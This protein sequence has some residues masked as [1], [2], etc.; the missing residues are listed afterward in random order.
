MLV[1]SSS[2]QQADSAPRKRGLFYSKV[3]SMPAGQLTP[4]QRARQKAALAKHHQEGREGKA[5]TSAGTIRTPK[6]QGKVGQQIKEMTEPATQIIRK[7]VEGGLVKRVEPWLDSEQQQTIL[8]TDPSASKEKLVLDNGKE[9]D[10]LATY[11]PVSK[12]KV[13][14]A[15]WVVT[16]D[17]NI[18]KANQESLL[19]KLE[20]AVKE[21]K[22][23]DE[24]AIPKED[25]Q[26]A[27]RE[28]AE[29]GQHIRKLD[30]P[31]SWDEESEDSEDDDY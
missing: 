14:I 31:T 9:I 30:V 21:K 23:K 26:Q 3:L 1:V 15:K 27:A 11:V 16:T 10:V 24:G 8:R 25:P 18:K 29:K 13:E 6:I 28:A 7:A 17:I 19:R 4:E 22:A 20:L 2:F 12:D 5:K